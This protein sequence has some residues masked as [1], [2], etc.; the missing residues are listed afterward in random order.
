MSEIIT[1]RVVDTKDVNN[2][3]KTYMKEYRQK[4]KDKMREYARKWYEIRIRKNIN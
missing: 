1:E 3:Q 2:A 4:N